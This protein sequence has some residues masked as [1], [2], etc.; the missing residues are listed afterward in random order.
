MADL[1]TFNISGPNVGT[2]G[3]FTEVMLSSHNG[4]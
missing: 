1:M 4:L 3:L 2:V